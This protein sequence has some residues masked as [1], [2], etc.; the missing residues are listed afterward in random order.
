MDKPKRMITEN[1]ERKA[2]EQIIHD[3]FSKYLAEKYPESFDP[4]VP[5]ELIYSGSKS[6]TEHIEAVGIDAGK[7]VLSPTRTYAPLIRKVL[8]AYRDH[9]DGMIHCSGGAQTKVLHFVDQV[10]IIKDNLFP[11]P[12]LFRLI[13][14]ESGTSWKEM[15]QVFNCGHRMELY[16]PESVADSIIGISRSFGIDAQVVGRVLDSP[17]TKLTIASPRGTFDY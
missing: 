15:F 4:D 13:Q 16:V 11:V 7:L 12:P 2:F 8:A 10:H 14:E 17:K 9:I 6:L 5:S 3:V 1:L